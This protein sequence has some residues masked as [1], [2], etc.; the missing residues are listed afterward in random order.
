MRSGTEGKNS[1]KK[2]PKPNNII[3]IPT[4]S[5]LDFFKWWCIFL[6]P[7]VNLRDSEIDIIANLLKHRMELSQYISDPTI[8]D[9]AMMGNAT[10]EKILAECG[11]TLKNFYVVMSNLRKKKVIVNNSLNSRLI[12]NMRK[13]DN[14]HFQL[15]ILF[16][17]YDAG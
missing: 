15:L 6:K 2:L 16:K 11:I 7:F 14:G 13:D 17:D 9:S 3:T 1:N 4:K 8:L 10:R 12:P 5:T